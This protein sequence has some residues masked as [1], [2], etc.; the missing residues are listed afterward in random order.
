MKI[1]FIITGNQEDAT[2]NTIPKIKKTRASYWTPEAQ[3]YAK[4]K[5]F[6]QH[7]FGVALANHLINNPQDQG[8]INHGS[9]VVGKATPKPIDLKA[10]QHACMDIKIYWK[11][12]AHADSENCFG[13][14]AD[15]LFV[16]DR[17]LDGSFTGEVS[18]DGKGR[19]EVS[20]LIDEASKISR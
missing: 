4:W 11:N 6:V 17:N 16:Q 1:E 7:A 9:G 15:A 5:E 12:K 20:I 18:A 3:R 14:I 10:D 19:V 8:T 2:G 13:S